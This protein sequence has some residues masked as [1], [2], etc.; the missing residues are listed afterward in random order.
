MFVKDLLSLRCW[1]RSFRCWKHYL[2]LIFHYSFFADDTF[3][4][5][6]VAYHH[7]INLND[8]ALVIIIWPMVSPC[9]AELKS[10]CNKNA[11]NPDV[12]IHIAPQGLF[13]HQTGHKS[14]S[15]PVMKP[16][17]HILW[18]MWHH[19]VSYDSALLC[20]AETHKR[21]PRVEPTL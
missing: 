2:N 19:D 1:N 11:P 10:H 7:L 9:K 3:R 8:I 12:S 13:I 5:I 20:H 17:G 15:R 14:L 16:S 18:H 6:S 21:I 4:P